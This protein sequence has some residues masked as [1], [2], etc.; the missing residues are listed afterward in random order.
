MRKK[1][2]MNWKITA[3]LL[4]MGLVCAPAFA[5][6]PA[7]PGT[8]NY[9]E[10]TAYLDGRQLNNQNVGNAELDPGQVLSTAQGKAEVLLTPGIFLRLDD[11]SAVKMISPDLTNTQ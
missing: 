1:A 2:M 10:G 5:A 8:V 3:A 7:R 6:N 11:N 9:I 4:G